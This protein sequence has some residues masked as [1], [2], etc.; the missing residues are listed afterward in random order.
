MESNYINSSALSLS[1]ASSSSSC[2]SSPFSVLSGTS[3][4][5]A[6]KVSK[7]SVLTNEKNKFNDNMTNHTY[8]NEFLSNS[9][10]TDKSDQMDNALNNPCKKTQL[11]FND[12]FT[13]KSMFEDSN[14]IYAS[15]NEQLKQRNISNT[16]ITPNLSNSFNQQLAAAAF[17]L[18]GNLLQKNTVMDQQQ[19]TYQQFL[20]NLEK[21]NQFSKIAP[22]LASS[23]SFQILP[24]FSNASIFSTDKYYNGKVFNQEK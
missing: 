15:Y 19:N 7:Y 6:P 5:L 24:K 17:A 4:T 9:H 10:N 14:H 2:S 8:L 13:H 3:P 21:N 16:S 22:H 11:A 18:Y 23:S 20:S 1:S 12:K